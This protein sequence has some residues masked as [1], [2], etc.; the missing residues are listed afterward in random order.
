MSVV[1][2]ARSRMQFNGDGNRLAL[3]GELT[4]KGITR[5]I[6]LDGELRGSVVDGDGSDR[7]AL[8]LRGELDR[9]DYGLLWN[10][11]LE[12]GNLVLGDTVELVLDVAAVRVD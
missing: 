9:S 12:T 8:A 3:L 7:I 5:P 11:V 6:A 2:N 10:R 4:I 1:E